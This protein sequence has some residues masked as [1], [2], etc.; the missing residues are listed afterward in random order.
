MPKKN[1]Q[2][3]NVLGVAAVGVSLA[4][5]AY[6][7]IGLNKLSHGSWPFQPD[8]SLIGAV[9]VILAAI[10]T[11]AVCIYVVAAEFTVPRV[12]WVAA[13]VAAE[14]V[15]IGFAV[16]GRM[17]E[18]ATTSRDGI[19]LAIAEFLLILPLLGFAVFRPPPQK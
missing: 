14:C 11:S 8:I 6:L 4:H 17:L 15:N 16:D 10:V 9:I 3:P 12:L 5:L 2:R 18:M 19:L 7:L 1:T 13:I